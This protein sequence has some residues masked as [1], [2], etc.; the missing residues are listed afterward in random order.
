MA[1]SEV[2]EA[3]IDLATDFGQRVHADCKSSKWNRVTNELAIPVGVD[4]KKKAPFIEVDGIKLEGCLELKTLAKDLANLF[5]EC[6]LTSLRAMVPKVIAIWKDGQIGDKA[7]CDPD[8]HF[9]V[10]LNLRLMGSGYVAPPGMLS[11]A[12]SVGLAMGC[13]H[14]EERF[15]MLFGF[16]AG[17]KL[18]VSTKVANIQVLQQ[19]YL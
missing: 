14:G 4:F 11:A 18:A 17:A 2:G 12:G 7:T 16:S 8:D 10:T 9:A 13:D 1:F 15:E 19:V 6:F 5:S 3:L